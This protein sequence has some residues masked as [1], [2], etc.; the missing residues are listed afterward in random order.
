MFAF[1]IVMPLL[2]CD[3]KKNAEPYVVE[4]KKGIKNMKYYSYFGI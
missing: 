3:R 4:N 2:H 1:I